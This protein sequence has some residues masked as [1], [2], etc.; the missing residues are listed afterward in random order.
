MGVQVALLA[1]LMGRLNAARQTVIE[2]WASRFRTP[3]LQSAMLAIIAMVLITHLLYLAVLTP[4]LVVNLAGL[5]NVSAGSEA[6][7]RHSQS[8]AIET[9]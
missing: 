8:A 1:Y 6:F 4:H 3:P 7:P 2:A 5:A 9:I